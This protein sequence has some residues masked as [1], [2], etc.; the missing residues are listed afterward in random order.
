MLLAFLIYFLDESILGN[1]REDRFSDLPFSDNSFATEFNWIHYGEC[2]GLPSSPGWGAAGFPRS[3]CGHSSQGG[4]N[5]RSVPDPPELCPTSK[6]SVKVVWQG[7]S[8]GDQIVR[9]NTVFPLL[10]TYW[11]LSAGLSVMWLH[12]EIIPPRRNLDI[13]S[14]YQWKILFYL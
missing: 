3:I 4:K 6:V 5:M 14:L 7:L 2:V 8:T 12:L 1:P 10:A 13:K 11:F 9:L